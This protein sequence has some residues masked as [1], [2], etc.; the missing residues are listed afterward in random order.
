MIWYLFC[1]S[2]F[3]TNIFL[4]EEPGSGVKLPHNSLFIFPLSSQ[5]HINDGFNLHDYGGWIGKVSWIQRRMYKT[6]ISV[7]P[8]VPNYSSW[9]TGSII[10]LAQMKQKMLP[11][12]FASFIL[13][14][15]PLYFTVLYIQ[16]LK[17]YRLKS[18]DVHNNFEI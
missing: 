14:H 1:Q 17:L 6:R 11:N 12:F 9:D 18:M 16:F 5:C 3:I 8:K 13:L 2:K 4:F 10:L 15:W 7:T